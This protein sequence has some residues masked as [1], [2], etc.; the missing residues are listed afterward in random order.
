MAATSQQGCSPGDRLG[1]STGSLSAPGLASCRLFSETQEFH[2]GW[3][4]RPLSQR[5]AG[6]EERE[7]EPGLKGCIHAFQATRSH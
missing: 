3:S 7:Q 5:E 1:P 2:P 4:P 6:R